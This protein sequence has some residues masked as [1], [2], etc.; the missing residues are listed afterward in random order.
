MIIKPKP[1]TS[2]KAYTKPLISIKDKAKE[3]AMQY[4]ITENML[5]YC[6]IKV[7]NHNE[8]SYIKIV[9]PKD[10]SYINFTSGIKGYISNGKDI[11]TALFCNHL[12]YHKDTDYKNSIRT[13]SYFDDSSDYSLRFHR[14]LNDSP[15]NIEIKLKAG[16]FTVRSRIYT[17]KRGNQYINALYFKIDKSLYYET[18]SNA[19]EGLKLKI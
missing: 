9:F 1:C 6:K 11:H 17:K 19:S 3:L 10:D 13:Y 7:I 4:G 12:M 15:C 14:A 18:I 8:L 2:A 16:T 5:I